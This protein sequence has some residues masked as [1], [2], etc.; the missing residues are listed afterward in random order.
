MIALRDL[1]E[2]ILILF[3]LLLFGVIIYTG[4]KRQT[5][6]QTWEEIKEILM[7]IIE[8]KNE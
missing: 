2:A 7:S 5:L 6:K 4:F 1:A 3:V 8:T